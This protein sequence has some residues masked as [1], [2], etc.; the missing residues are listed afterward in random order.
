MDELA[1]LGVPL[2]ILR[3]ALS[4]QN[5]WRIRIVALGLITL[6]VGVGSQ[7]LVNTFAAEVPD[8]D[9]YIASNSSDVAVAAGNG[10]HLDT[11]IIVEVH[12]APASLMAVSSA[13]RPLF[14]RCAAKGKHS[15]SRSGRTPLSLNGNPPT[16]V[17]LGHRLSFN[18]GAL[19]GVRFRLSRRA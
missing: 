9:G 5:A 2:V 12:Y 14:H 1:R 8:T 19:P 4:W 6:L 11:C 17:F 15:T 10:A 16:R 13:D 3:S 18:A 7:V